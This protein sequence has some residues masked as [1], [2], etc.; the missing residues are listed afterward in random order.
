MRGQVNTSA[1]KQAI[2][3]GFV[4]IRLR[5]DAAVGL[6]KE[7]MRRL[8]SVILEC[9]LKLHVFPAGGLPCGGP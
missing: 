5:G 1:Q 8:G 7:E 4:P 9:L 6:L 3:L 2:L